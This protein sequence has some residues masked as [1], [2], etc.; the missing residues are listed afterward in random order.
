MTALTQYI[1]LYK[2]NAKAIQAKSP[3][4]LNALRSAALLA[5][6]G[7]QL[8]RKGVEDYEATDLEEVFAPD[9]GVNINRVDLTADPAAAFHCDV[10]NLSTCLYFFYNDIFHPSRTARRHQPNGVIVESFTEAAQNHPDLLKRYYG[11]LTKLTDPTVALNTLLAQEGMLVY[12]PDGVEA[13]KPI[14]LVNL[15]NAAAPVMTVRRILVILGEN[16]KAHMLMCDHTQNTAVDYLSSQVVEI[17]AGAHSTLDYYDLEENGAT[18]HR[19]STIYVDQHEGSDVLVNGITLVN[20]LTRNNYIIDVNGEHCETRLLGMTIAS[21]TQH[22]DTHTFISHNAPRCHS[23]EM[24]KY[25]LNDTAVGAFSGKILVKPNCPKI[26]A[27]QGNRNI[28][29]SATAKMYTKPQLEIYTD[30][31]KCSHGATV[32]QLDEESLFYMR[33]RGIG[34]EEA[35]MLLM[36]AF[37]SDIVDSIRFEA[38]RDRMRHLVEKRFI[39]TLA[40][41]SECAGIGTCK[42]KI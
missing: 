27:Y 8:P 10:P 14:Q 40:K 19:V 7:A 35:R 39:G 9:Y 1:D 34:L 17:I 41:C 11:S 23:N 36:Q 28:C 16:A 30:D 22:S 31:V 5:L 18:T 38:L 20:G 26:D 33:T 13:T 4:A 3:E 12:I 32:G 37:M 15:L 21:G 2:E 24:F 29:A 42:N 25:V 6:E